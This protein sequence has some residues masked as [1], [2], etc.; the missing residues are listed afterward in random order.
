M[1]SSVANLYFRYPELEPRRIPAKDRAAHDKA[2]LDNCVA[3]RQAAIA[4]KKPYV[5]RKRFHVNM[6]VAAKPT[7]AP[8]GE[9]IRA[10][11]PIPRE[12]PFQTDFEIISTSSPV[13]HMDDEK[14]PIRCL[15]LEQAAKKD[16]ETD[17]KLEYNYT[18]HGV[19]FEVSPE[20]VRPANPNDAALKE[21]TREA[22]HVVFTP[23]IRALSQQIVGDEK[24]PYLKAKKFYLD[25][26]L[27][28]PAEAHPKERLNDIQ[29]AIASEEKERKQVATANTELNKKY[30]IAISKA[31]A[32]YLK[33][34]LT[35]AQAAYSIAAE[36]KPTEVE[37]QTQ[38]KLINQKLEEIRNAEN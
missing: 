37:P 9:T 27:I 38:L 18:V 35:N 6:T 11:V 19:R 26:A 23:E 15:Y 29:S 25:A 1:S 10:W 14:S 5:L 36:L 22:P 34:D 24:N 13:K 3:I 12:Y 33:E 21:F 32:Y 16:K 20:A 7:A 4:E 8:P 31:Q 30:D 28:K 17:F 2:V